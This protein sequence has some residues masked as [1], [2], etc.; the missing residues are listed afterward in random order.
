M[1]GEALDG[2]PVLAPAALAQDRRAAALKDLI[3]LEPRQKIRVGGLYRQG[4][5]LIAFPFGHRGRS[6]VQQKQSLLDK[7][8][9]RSSA[10]GQAPSD[11]GAVQ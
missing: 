1:A 6:L 7:I 9:D 11:Q 4:Q 3:F 10:S 2:V 8:S 5:P